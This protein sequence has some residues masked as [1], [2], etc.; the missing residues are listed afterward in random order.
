LIDADSG[1]RT[2]LAMAGRIL[3]RFFDGKILDDL[4]EF[5]ISKNRLLNGREAAV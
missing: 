5:L 1:S 4:Y 3:L 2:G